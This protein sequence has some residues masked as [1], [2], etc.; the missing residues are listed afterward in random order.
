MTPT[1]DYE[2]YTRQ[3]YRDPHVAEAYA[4]RLR[5]SPVEWGI[6]R[7]ER[8]A[9]AGG[10]RALDAARVGVVVD[11]PAG[12]GKLTAWLSER[13]DTYLALDVS[14]AMLSELPGSSWRAQ[15]DATQLPLAD[16]SV[17]CVV[18]L[19][20]LHRVPDDVADRMVR[21]ALRVS[22]LGVVASY[23]GVPALA[24]LHRALQRAS[25]RG[26]TMT[27]TRSP[28]QFAQLAARAGGQK[29]FDRSISAGVTAERVCAIRPR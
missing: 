13:A 28:Q 14:T 2:S 29:V 26:G 15:A 21:D 17:D 7:L 8:A 12:T 24:P 4:R 25:G 1:P 27:T 20:L 22:R 23:A 11:V 5:R 6:G 19:R 18:M 3:H 10:L 16:S 9:V